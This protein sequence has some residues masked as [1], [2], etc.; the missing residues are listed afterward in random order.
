MA[1]VGQ[2]VAA[3][4]PYTSGCQAGVCT[5]AQ[6]V[7]PWVNLDLSE[8]DITDGSGGRISYAIA[9]TN[10]LQN[11]SGM[12]R[13]PPS[14]YPAGNLVVQNIAVTQITATAA[15]VLISH[16]K[17]RVYGFRATTGA[18]VP[19]GAIVSVPQLANSNGTPFVQDDSAYAADAEYFDD[20][21]RWRSA[22]MIIQFCGSNACGNPA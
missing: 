2:A 9:T 12:V 11:T 17:D 1:T 4:T 5:S 15:Y 7:V 16:G 10:T 22:P 20:L 19:A 3:G 14:T 8:N 13:T 18:Q 21:V 6:G